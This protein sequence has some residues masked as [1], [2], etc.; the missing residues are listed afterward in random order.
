M[1]FQVPSSERAHM[2]AFVSA[3]PQLLDAFISALSSCHPQLDQQAFGLKLTTKLKDVEGATP[4]SIASIARTLFALHAVLLQDS[5]TT[6]SEASVDVV[7]GLIADGKFPEPQEGWAKFKERLTKL[8]ASETVSLTAKAGAVAFESPRHAQGFRV[9]TDA[10]P[11]FGQNLADGP[12]AY[13]ILHTLQ[14]TYFEDDGNSRDWFL[15]VDAED[16]GALDEVVARAKAKE[17]SLRA[18]LKS[19]GVPLMSWKEPDNG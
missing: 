8:L 19:Q 10:R 6:P 1:T 9:L 4:Q 17:V 3:K 18:A 12:K 15:S 13:A 7:Q 11:I 14:I 5:K 16:L 2:A